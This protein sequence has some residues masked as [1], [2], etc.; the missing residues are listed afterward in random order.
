M[1]IRT[2]LPVK[3]FL[4]GLPHHQSLMLVFQSNLL[5]RDRD[6][7]QSPVPERMIGDETS[8][9]PPKKPRLRHIIED[10]TGTDLCLPLIVNDEALELPRA[11]RYPFWM[12][13]PDSTENSDN[14]I[15]AT[16]GEEQEEKLYSSREEI[17]DSNEDSES[18]D[19]RD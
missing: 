18:E 7:V 16:D 5:F 17:S 14:E 15:L 6:S 13:V 2:A 8:P 1:N 10:T 9:V 3:V 4:A 11:L 19:W 12:E